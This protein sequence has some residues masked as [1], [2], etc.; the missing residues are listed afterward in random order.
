MTLSLVI[1]HGLVH[2]GTGAEPRRVDIGIEGDRIVAVGDIPATD[3]AEIDAA[4]LVVAPGLI[5]VLSQAW[6]TI[7]LDGTCQSDLVQG[8]TTEVFGEG[9]S[10]GPSSP[11]LL[12]M[13]PMRAGTRLDFPRLSDGLDHIEAR[14][15]SVNV[16]SFIGGHN[17]RALAV[18][19]DDRPLTEKDRKST[20]LNSS[21]PSISRMPSS[22]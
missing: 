21:H 12:D 1:R 17:L 19:A 13:V 10:L 9:V 15:T 16:A 11:A 14:G 6:Q 22:A 2:D 3:C 8:V 5:N 7:Q 20:R 18:G 4:G